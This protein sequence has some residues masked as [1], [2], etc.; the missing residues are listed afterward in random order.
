MADPAAVA[1]LSRG[2][3]LKLIS[4]SF[5]GGGDS[6]GDETLDLA[7]MRECIKVPH[8]LVIYHVAIV[9]ADFTRNLVERQDRFI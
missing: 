4:R 5:F 6:G 1:K 3:D 2:G 9:G 8:N 7:E